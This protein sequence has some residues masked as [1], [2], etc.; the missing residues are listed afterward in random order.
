MN[1]RFEWF[2]PLRTA[3]LIFF[4][5]ITKSFRHC[6]EGRV[7]VISARLIMS[8]SWLFIMWNL[9]GSSRVALADFFFENRSTHSGVFAG[10]VLSIGIKL[11]YVVVGAWAWIF[12][13][14]EH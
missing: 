13:Y 11:L 7:N 6:C 8:R 1:S 10:R 4:G 2:Y 14:G 12:R 9:C 5:S 3:K